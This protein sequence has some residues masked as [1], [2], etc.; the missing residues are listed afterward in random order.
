MPSFP[1][2]LFTLLLHL[3]L[4]QSFAQTDSTSY[5]IIGDILIEGN[6]KTKENII[7]RELNFKSGD[8]ILFKDQEELFRWNKNR[9]FNTNLFITVNLHLIDRGQSLR[10]IIIIVQERWYIYPVPIFELADRNFN[11]WW[12]DRNRDPKRINVGVYYI[13]KN[14]RGRNETLRLKAQLGFT[15]KFELFYFIPYINKNQKSGLNFE[16]SVIRN[17]QIP[18]YTEGNKLIY[19]DGDQIVKDRFRTA[20]IYTYRKKF[21]QF[22]SIGAGFYY[23][24]IADTIRK[25]NP[26]FLLNEKTYQRYFSLK[27][28]FTSDKRDVA[29]YPLRGHF[30]RGEIEKLGIGIFNDIN[31]INFYSEGAL[32]KA[33]SKKIYFAAGL[34]QKI[35]FPEKQPYLQI[36]GLGYD[37]DYVSGYELYVIDGSHFSLAKT[38][39]KWQ[40]FSTMKDLESVPVQEF[41]SLPL[42]LYL[43][44]HADAGYVWNE[45][46]YL[47]NER[48]TNKF[49]MGGGLGLDIVSYYDFVLR[50]EYSINLHGN[51]GFFLHFKSSI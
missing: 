46:V 3:V 4:F 31:Q 47:G 38:N 17:K 30:F 32:F 20:I 43:K 23:N 12:Q 19:F 8:T 33:L 13:Q 36:R 41:Q 50:M 2:L 11:E 34:K 14:V 25:L 1:K 35:S 15:R 45:F 39:L 21:Y 44:L 29:Y 37:K 22:H 18:V 5:I 40:L 16:A 28:S 9:I 49:L 42:A 7:L 24:S 10:D 27:Y 51:H 26:D 48:L 6:K